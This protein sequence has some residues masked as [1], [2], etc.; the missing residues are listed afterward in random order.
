MR[1]FLCILCLVFSAN[2]LGQQTNTVV[3]VSYE[4]FGAKLDGK[5]D[6]YDAIYRCHQYANKNNL[7]VFVSKGKIYIKGTHSPIVVKTSTDLSRCSFIID[8]SYC[9][10][11]IYSFEEDDDN[12]FIDISKQMM[13]SKLELTIGKMNIPSLTNY[14]HSFFTIEGDRVLGMRPGNPPTPY[15]SRE[16]FTIM[17]DGILSDG[18]LYCDYTKDNIKLQVKSTTTRPI[19]VKLPTIE[20]NIKNINTSYNKTFLFTRN[21]VEVFLPNELKYIQ[22]P[23]YGKISNPMCLIPFQY[24]YGVKVKGGNCENKGTL[25]NEEL[26]RTC[27]VI[28]FYQCSNIDVENVKM[29]RGWGALNTEFIKTLTIRDSYI[30]RMDNHFG[31]SDVLMDNCTVVGINNFANIGYGFG[32]VRISNCKWIIANTSSTQELTFINFR[33]D[34]RLTYRGSISIDNVDIYSTIP[35]ASIELLKANNQYNTEYKTYIEGKNTISD[36]VIKNVNVDSSVHKL[37]LFGG[38]FSQT[39]PAMEIGKI[40]FDNVNFENNTEFISTNNVIKNQSLLQ[41]KEMNLSNCHFPNLVDGKTDKK[42][43]ISKISVNNTVYNN[44]FNIDAYKSR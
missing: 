26:S 21:N 11:K 41:I 2:L 43:F 17:S 15:M 34:L 19:T 31:I 6:D 27:Y 9:G 37:T 33:E 39:A 28:N 20:F 32:K 29:Y 3:F 13:K 22:Y 24:C 16:C 23:S 7:P 18:K 25:P 1:Y 4:S 42:G 30:N 35:N 10:K 5:T 12:R 44:K 38:Y 40:Y 14:K 36:I 8:D